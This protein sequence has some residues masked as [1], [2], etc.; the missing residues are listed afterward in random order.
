VESSQQK[1][2][3]KGETG[4]RCP[5]HIIESLIL[6]VGCGNQAFKGLSGKVKMPNYGY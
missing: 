3:L 4:K 2:D 5:C 1:L 6:D